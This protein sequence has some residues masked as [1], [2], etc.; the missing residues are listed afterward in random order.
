MKLNQ[1]LTGIAIVATSISF[2]QNANDVLLTI[3][4]NTITSSEFMAIYNKNN[5]E[6][7]SADKKSIEEYLDLYLNFKLKVHEAEVQGYDTIP[8]F[9][10]ELNGYV[11][12]LASPY[13]VDN[14]FTE[15][16]IKEAYNR[17]KLEVRASH[18]MVKI[19]EN[20]TPEDT[21][22]AWVKI[23][24]IYK[25]TLS[26]SNFT[27]LAVKYSDDPSA[28]Q[29]DG[30]LG[31]FSAFRMVYPFESAAFNTPVG[32]IAKPIRTS[33]GYHIIKVVD[34]RPARGEIKAAHIMIISNDKS[35]PEEKKKASMKIAEIYQELKAGEAFAKLANTYSDDRG[36]AQ[37]GGDLGWFGAGRMVPV[38]EEAAFSL[39][40]NG[41][42]SEPFLSQFG[43]HIVLREDKRNLGTYEEEY[44]ELE[45]K[46]KGDRRSLGSEHALVQK[47]MSDYNVKVKAKTKTAFYDV[48]DS[49]YF[50]NA[51]DKEKA[52]GLRAT[53]LTINDKT[54]GKQKVVITQ[55]DFTEYLVNKMR[56]QKVISI[57][58]LIDKEF[59]GFVDYKMI[60]YET[61]ILG[62]KHSDYKALVTEY[63]DGILL[64][65]I[66]EK[67][68]W[69]KAMSDS[70]GLDAFYQAHQSEYLWKER[71]DAKLYICNTKEIAGSV[72]EMVLAGVS[73]S[74]IQAEINKDSQLAVTI[75]TGKFEDGKE[76][77]LSKIKWVKGISVIED[78]NNFVVVNVLGK[79][80]P[81]PKKLKDVKGLV[82]SSYQDELDRLWVI[83]LRE[84]Y[85]YT[86][87][88]ETL[89]NIVK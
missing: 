63:H 56:N 79:L 29:N 52:S 57:P 3:E 73:D 78:D 58:M 15:D 30:D 19:P 23:N 64:F 61:S 35:T 9:I 88:Q 40:E 34:S 21:L 77:Y 75:R 17:S 46:V 71:L 37:K 41:N 10:N 74:T 53:M 87:N 27:E 16:L 33:Y 62:L 7:Q 51:W 26:D 69:K 13:L 80:D 67:E 65:E 25:K 1:I 72:N 45:K 20:P 76:D 31:Y 12:Q 68:V 8:S 22:S 36:S 81:E 44:G 48:L 32:G 38:F 18:I 82:T 59:D 54:Y 66:M 85:S 43:W 84:K 4:G 83:A 70:T 28:K 2:A 89:S 5:V 14:Q 47:L 55:A 49:T 24:D 60:E 39:A 86:I 11:D 6:I 42:F 50:A